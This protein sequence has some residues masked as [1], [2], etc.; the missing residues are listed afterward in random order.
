MALTTVQK[1]QALR[2][3]VV[4][5]SVTTADKFALFGLIQTETT[6][7]VLT[8]VQKKQLLRIPIA[9]ATVSTSDKFA[10]L[11]LVE[12]GG[13]GNATIQFDLSWIIDPTFTIT[14]QSQSYDGSI[15]IGLREFSSSFSGAIEST[16]NIARISS[17][18]VT[19]PTSVQVKSIGM[20]LLVR[21]RHIS[22]SIKSAGISLQINV[23]ES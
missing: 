20:S 11:G 4:D 16:G 9:D 12:P 18:T 1:K 7:S 23:P 14:E 22:L 5:A 17:Y 15:G 19:R 3:P 13:G 8:S 6:A 21:T 2:I 10:L